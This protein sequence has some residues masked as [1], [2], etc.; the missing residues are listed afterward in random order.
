LKQEL[1]FKPDK[2]NKKHMDFGGGNK[3]VTFKL[4]YKKIDGAESFIKIQVNFLEQLIYPIRE[5]E[6]IPI[7]FPF[8]ERLD[9]EYPEYPEMLTKK[10]VLFVYDLREIAS[11]KVRAVL[12]RKGFKARDLIDLYKLSTKGINVS[13]I[14]VSAIKKTLA[15]LKYEKYSASIIKKKIEDEYKLGNEA[16]LMIT[17]LEKEYPAYVQKVIKELD[18]ISQEIIKESKK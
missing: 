5:K 1:D 15:M 14:K 18:L 9:L 8:N 12:T 16:N 17:P 3:F 13:D 2:S 4:Y 7:G 10:S 6:I 11:E